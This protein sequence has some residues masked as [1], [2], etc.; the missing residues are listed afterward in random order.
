MQMSLSPISLSFPLVIFS[1][2]IVWTGIDVFR[3]KSQSPNRPVVTCVIDSLCNI[4]LVLKLGYWSQPNDIQCAI[5]DAVRITKLDD[6]GGSEFVERYAI[7]R[8]IGLQRS[9]A[10]YTPF[11]YALCRNVLTKRMQRK[12]EFVAY[13]KKH[14]SVCETKIQVD[15]WTVGPYKI[16]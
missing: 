8:K 11:G 3:R 13:L 5:K 14:P 2:S 16:I 10:K 15:S 4:F 12:L 1:V 9:K 6:F 7:A